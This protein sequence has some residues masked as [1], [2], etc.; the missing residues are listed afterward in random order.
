M[1]VFYMTELA[2]TTMKKKEIDCSQNFAEIISC[3]YR[4][5][6]NILYTTNNNK[7]QHISIEKFNTSIIFKEN[8]DICLHQLGLGQNFLD[9]VQKTYPT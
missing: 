7:Y 6:R 3:Q 1:A 5:K 9:K 8:I 2:L 4:E